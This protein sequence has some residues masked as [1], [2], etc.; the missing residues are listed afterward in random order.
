LRLIKPHGSINWLYCDACRETF[1]VPPDTVENVAQ[2]LFGEKDW[3]VLEKA[4]LLTKLPKTLNPAC[5]HCGS[6]ALGTR[7][8][9]FSYRKAL[10]FPMHNAS[11][12]SAERDL[13]QSSHWV[14]IGYSMP[15]ADYEFKQLLKR[16]QLSESIRPTIT[17]ITAGTGGADTVTRFEKFFGKVDKERFYFD[18]G[19][20][21]AALDHLGT[22]GML[23]A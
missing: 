12:R 3:H 1:W 11:W 7:F 13:K 6:L 9:T 21:G 2:T 20:D 14:F 22:L 5:P 10:D 23:R 4:K 17:L 16:V 18:N 19:L 15:G 8:A